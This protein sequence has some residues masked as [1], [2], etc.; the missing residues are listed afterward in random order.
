MDENVKNSIKARRD[1]I[2][3]AYEVGAGEK[4][5]VDTLFAE[6]EK[7]GK[8]CKDVMEFEAEFAKSSLNQQYLDLFTEVATS[9][10]PKVGA[11]SDDAKA[12]GDKKTGG[13]KTKGA[14]AVVGEMIA[15]GIVAGD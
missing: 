11:G 4:K 12:G 1:A 9:S 5:K 6:I 13:A 15:E 10:Q 3:N 8:S 14:G 2:F 7:L